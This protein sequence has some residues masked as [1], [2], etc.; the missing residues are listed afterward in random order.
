MSRKSKL[1]RMELYKEYRKSIQKYD[2]IDINEDTKMEKPTYA[3]RVFKIDSK[4]NRKVKKVEDNI[5]KSYIR[6]RRV[7]LFLYILASVLL[8]G[9]LVTIIVIC[10]V[11]YL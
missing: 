7:N 4:R 8:I 3:R 6:K 11:I 9:L 10:G 5:Y 1:T 2:F